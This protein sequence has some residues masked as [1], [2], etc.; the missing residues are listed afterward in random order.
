ML[1]AVPNFSEGRD[2]DVIAAI[3]AAIGAGAAVLDVHSDATHNR[4]VFTLAGDADALPAAVLAGAR[5]AEQRIDMRARSGAHPCIGALDVS[6]IVYPSA[7]LRDAAR[8]GALAV[9]DA[10]SGLGIP[11]FLYGELA[12][13]E[14]R[15]E[16]A[17][18]RRGGL[19]ELTL[20]MRRGELDADRG[21]RAP[22][23]SA[24]ATLVTARPPLAA[25]NVVLDTS[26]I[27]VGRA[28]AAELREA[29]GGLTGVRALAIELPGGRVQVSTN[30]HDPAGLP[31]RLVVEEIRRLAGLHGAGPADAELVGLIPEAAL[32]GYPEDVPIT[33]FDPELHVI[34]RRIAKL[35]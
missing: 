25:F 13:T 27:E 8:G 11:V 18:F 34:E 31:L 16:R 10:V 19:E 2:E 3:G 1:L 21:P 7:D 30:V 4:S 24:G 28:V 20:R 29:G 5:I 15:S 23:P 6:P 26:D 9:A 35:R 12:A 17:Y 14:Q 32:E 33:A 22:H